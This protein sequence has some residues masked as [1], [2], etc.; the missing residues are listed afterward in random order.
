MDLIEAVK[1]RKSIRGYKPTPVARDVIAQII[2]VAKWAPSG[3]NTQPWEFFVLGGEVLAKLKEVLERQF[4]GRAEPNPDFPVA[5][6]LSEV[7]RERRVALVSALYPLLGF[8]R[9]DRER[10]QEWYLKMM[11]AFDAP[12]VIFV[13][14]EADSGDP[15]VLFNIGAVTQT[16]AL[17]ALEFG[18][19]TCIEGA[20]VQYPDVIREI[21]DIPRSKKLAIGIAIG[22]PDWDLPAN[23]FRS[24]REPLEKIVF[25]RG[26]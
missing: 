5:S 20:L 17:V 7:Y 16:I 13:A 11:R 18:L 6:S 19:G 1:S 21:A 15:W 12:N 9:E 4:L 2:E 3:S 8:S 22:Y 14:T 24:S 26:L 10:R 23:K 25:W